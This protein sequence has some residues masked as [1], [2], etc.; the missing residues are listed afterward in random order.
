MAKQ[1][2]KL[3]YDEV[4]GRL[5]ELLHGIA[6]GQ[7]PVLFEMES[8]LY[9]L[10]L[11]SDHLRLDE[12]TTESVSV[13]QMLADTAGAFKGLDRERLTRHLRQA[14]QQASRGRPA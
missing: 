8:R 12:Q 6:H 3:S 13:K 10:G 1:E 5:A 4:A 11:A 2:R 7:A 14:R 9:W